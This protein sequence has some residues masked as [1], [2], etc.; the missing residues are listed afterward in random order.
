MFRHVRTVLPYP[1]Q[2]GKIPD[3]GH[4]SLSPEVSWTLQGPIPHCDHPQAAGPP[5]IMM[6]S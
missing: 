2:V 1:V 5:T 6:P 4:G 3:V